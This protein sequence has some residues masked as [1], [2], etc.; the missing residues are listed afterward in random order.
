MLLSSE[1]SNSEA[2]NHPLEFEW[3][4]ASNDVNEKAQNTPWMLDEH[5]SFI[6]QAVLDHDLMLIGLEEEKAGAIEEDIF[7]S[8]SGQ[9]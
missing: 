1:L 9:C 7:L 4:T 2:P 6:C 8:M 5:D 3:G